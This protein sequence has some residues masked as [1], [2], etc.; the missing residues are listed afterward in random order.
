[1]PVQYVSLE[2]FELQVEALRK[3]IR[4]EAAS[5][6]RGRDP[7]ENLMRVQARIWQLEDRVQSLEKAVLAGSLIIM[8]LILGW[9]GLEIFYE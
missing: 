6:T 8:G 3:F 7:R 9:V 1:M 4:E 5:T 2:E